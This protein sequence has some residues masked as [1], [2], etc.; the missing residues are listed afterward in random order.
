LAVDSAGGLLREARLPEREARLLLARCTGQT[1]A[2]VA[3]FPERAVEGDAAARFRA[4][5]ARRVAG[6][7]VAYLLG[8]R[9]FFSRTFAVSP[10]V[11]IPRHETEMLVQRAL[12]LARDIARPVIADL[13]TGSG[14]IAVTLA[15]E[16]PGAT[17]AAID[18]STD[19]LALARRNAAALG[20]TGVEF[21]SG[22]WYEPLVGRSF[23]LIV[24]NP[25]YIADGDAHLRQGDLR[26]EPRAAL[27]GG[28]DGLAALRAVVAGAPR[29]LRPR[30][31]L[32]VEHGFDQGAAVRDLLREAGLAAIR[33]HRDLAGRERIGEA[34]REQ[35]R[36]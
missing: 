33:T 13:G 29:H 30:G 25:P 26:F 4:L 12:E 24:A 31:T 10:A 2:L 21:L 28:A 35:S 17:L 27:D 7:P 9:E 15:C 19:A 18:A 36:A 14:A 1:T 20:A 5:A 11:L 16:L 3:A 22:S 23:D 8:E 34:R 32:L 6:E